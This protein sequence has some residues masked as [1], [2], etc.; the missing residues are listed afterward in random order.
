MIAAPPGAEDEFPAESGVLIVAGGAE[1]SDS[2]A[3]ALEAVESEI[4]VI[5]DA[6]RPLLWPELVDELVAKLVARPGADGVIAAAPVTDTIKRADGERIAETPP[7]SELWAAQTPQVFRT[8]PLREALAD[9]TAR[10]SATDES[11]LIEARGGNVLLHETTRP[12]LK[13]TTPTDLLLATALL[14]GQTL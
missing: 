6:A 8:G 10:A 13:V 12:N 4:V 3:A 9:A 1:R 11:S 14:R 2:V 5:H 7:R